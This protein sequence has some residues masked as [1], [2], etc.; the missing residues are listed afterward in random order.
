MI[1]AGAVPAVVVKL[2]PHFPEAQYSPRPGVLTDLRPKFAYW[3]LSL[4][5]APATKPLIVCENVS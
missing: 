3:N 4:Y 5:F 2:T 1:A